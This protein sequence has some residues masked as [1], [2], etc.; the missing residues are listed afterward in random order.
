VNLWMTGLLLL[1][2]LV[3]W[4]LGK[5]IDVASER[6]QTRRAAVFCNIGVAVGI[7]ALFYFKYLDFLIQ[8]LNL[9][10]KIKFLFV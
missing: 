4:F 7:G 3:F 5:G 1:L 10:D 9:I 2:T 6:G 8:N